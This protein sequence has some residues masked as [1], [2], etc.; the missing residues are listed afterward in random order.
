MEPHYRR[1]VVDTL[2]PQPLR[3]SSDDYDELIDLVDDASVVLLGQASHGTH[4]FHRER[5]RIT[6]R[7][8][9]ER[10][11]RTI[12]LEADWPAASRVNR[13]L[14][15]APG[16]ESAEEA[17][18]GFHRFPAWM[19]RNAEMLDF[20]GWLR[21]HND[22]NHYSDSVGF[23]GL[24][25][26]SLYS[27]V[28]DVIGYLELIDRDIAAEA[29]ER[30]AC[31]GDFDG[32]GVHRRTPLERIDSDARREL[33]TRLTRLHLQG[34]SYLRRDSTAAEHDHFYAEQNA[35]LVAS[36]ARYYRA[37]LGGDAG[38]AS[39]RDRHMADTLVRL[40][41]HLER[42][43]EP[44]RVV[45]WAHN[46]HVGDA[47]LTDLRGEGQVSMGQ[48][49]RERWNEKA[50]LIGFTTHSGTVTA[51]SAWDAP[52]RQRELREAVP[53]SYEARFHELGLP[54]FL[55]DLRNGS[56]SELRAPRLERAIGV[57]YRPEDE[58]DS[59]Y[60]QAGLPGQFDAVIHLDETRALEPL[61][62]DV[63]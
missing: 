32:V 56:G 27:S 46:T 55:L 47:R 50:V 54:R 59:H 19:W 22:R 39:V 4:E 24:D 25:L 10:G 13:Y 40:V 53:G 20:I 31:L 17:L 23:F 37:M 42:R 62:H 63:L 28:A 38:S 30:Y 48:L 60:F 16:D 9:E 7:L 8:I 33:I 36:G 5:A 15:G 1:P 51:S 2:E 14:H 29:R 26:F 35:R 43:G 34:E 3:G 57:I 21:A 12:A 52:P 49:A 61:E 18:G 44:S 58:L 6:R 11:F 45:V 41:E